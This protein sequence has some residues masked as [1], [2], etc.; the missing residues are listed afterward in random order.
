[1][2]TAQRSPHTPEIM[3]WHMS[4]DLSQSTILGRSGS[5]A[6]TFIALCCGH[7]FHQ[8]NL[9]PPTNGTDPDNG[10]QVCLR[11][12]IISGNEIHDD[13]FEHDPVNVSVDE[14]EQIAGSKCHVEKLMPQL[15][16]FGHNATGQLS[17]VFE[18]LTE[19][20]RPNCSVV[21]S[22]ECAFL[23]IVNT[24]GS[25]MLID[26]HHHKQYGALISYA[27][28]NDVGHMA[29]WLPRMMHQTWKS[30][31]KT[32]SVTPAIYRQV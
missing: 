31:L 30:T 29:P 1:M 25:A 23:F 2:L 5:N 11:K 20:Q 8:A 16:V 19:T 27:Q 12:V 18:G 10:W 4:S 24:D 28:P 14:A 7:L 13:I 26:S 9:Q 15:D 17:T 22:D 6:C 21:I 3:E 32:T